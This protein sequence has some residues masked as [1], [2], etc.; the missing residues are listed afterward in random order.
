MGFNPN[1][2][3]P[4]K[5]QTDFDNREIP[6]GTY[7]FG[8]AWCKCPTDRSWKGRF[9]VLDGPFMGASCFILQGRDLS[10]EG[11]ANRLF[12]YAQSAGLDRELETGGANGMML[13]EAAIREHILGRAIKAKITKKTR[14]GEKRE[15]IDYDFAKFHAREEWNTHELAIAKA[16]EEKFAVEREASGGDYG[17]GDWGGSGSGSIDPMGG[18]FGDDPGPAGDE[19][20][21]GGDEW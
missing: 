18:S 12:Y 6:A 11:N 15:L 16:W 19:W 9:E 13:T 7:L 10:K 8:P 17:G 1:A 14:Q 3:K 21:G 20:G 4:T 5:P 2:H